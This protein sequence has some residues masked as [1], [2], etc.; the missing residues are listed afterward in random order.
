MAIENCGSSFAQNIEVFS[1][2]VAS[3][4][5]TVNE[6]HHLAIACM[7]ISYS[8]KL[9][10]QSYLDVI[11]AKFDNHVKDLFEF[12]TAR[13][14]SHGFTIVVSR[15]SVSASKDDMRF[16]IRG[17]LTQMKIEDTKMKKQALGNLYNVL[18]EDERFIDRLLFYLRN[19]EVSVQESTLK[20][21]SRLCYASEEAK[22]VI[23]DASFIPSL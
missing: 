16:Y 3:V 13:I 5:V 11:F 8:G 14:L 6:C 1:G 20:V 21:T 18:V 17:L 15:L 4:L 12:Y 2:L 19:G 7:D 22:K 23:G 9:L 10:M